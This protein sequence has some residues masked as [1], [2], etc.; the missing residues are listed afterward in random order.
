M[1]KFDG[2]DPYGLLRGVDTL[3]NG[4]DRDLLKHRAWD[5]WDDMYGGGRLDYMVYVLCDKSDPG[6]YI[7]GPPEGT[8]LRLNFRPKYIGHGQCEKGK[9]RA[10]CVESK[11]KGRQEDKPGEKYY[12]IEEMARKKRKIHTD[13]L[14]LYYTKEKAKIVEIKL[15]YLMKKECVDLTNATYTFTQVPLNEDDF[16]NPAPILFV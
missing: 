16:D 2:E 6:K 1:D 12:W 10:R 14:G 3:Y 9:R 5:K 7:Y 4:N 8:Q 15:L 11:G 13:I